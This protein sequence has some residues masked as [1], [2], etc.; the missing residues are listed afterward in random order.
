MTLGISSEYLLKKYQ[1]TIKMSAAIVISTLK[2]NIRQILIN[3]LKAYFS[4]AGFTIKYNEILKNQKIYFLEVK[5][6]M[7]K[8][9]S[10]S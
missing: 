7:S 10:L 1:K 4:S 2:V 8:G 6:S 9:I 5:Y 3:K